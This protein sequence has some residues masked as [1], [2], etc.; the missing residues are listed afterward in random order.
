MRD[1]RILAL[2]RVDLDI[3]TTAKDDYLNH[4]V[5]AA[6]GFI[7]EEGVTLGDDPEDEQMVEMY[8]AHL[9]RK[10]RD[11]KAAMPRMLRWALN[12]RLFGEREVPPNG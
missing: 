3:S 9:Y 10:R 8:A 7:R 2:L 1:G 11:E 6:K 12:C 4:L 5:Q